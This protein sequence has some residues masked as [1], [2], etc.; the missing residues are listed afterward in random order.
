[1]KVLDLTLPTPQHNLACEEA[2]IQ[3]CEEDGYED[4]ILRFWEPREHFAVLGY[5]GKVNSELNLISC[6]DL[7]VPVLRRCSG[8]GTVLQGPGCLNYALI[9]R[10]P[11][12]EALKGIT[13]T[14][15]FIMQ[16]LKNAL[17]PI[18]GPGIE[19][20]G[21]SDLA[22]GALKFSGN[23]QYRKRRFL[24]F[25]GTF[26]L[27]FD[28][29][30]VEKLLPIPLRQPPYRQ[31]RS[32]GDFLTNLNLPSDTIKQTLKR[33]WNATAELK[34]IPLDRIERLVRE[35]YG[36]EEWTFHF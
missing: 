3:W 5:S 9:L 22:L 1:M 13:E 35:R 34:E 10:I 23:A 14:N 2:L 27:R 8:G 28:I 24:L 31:N 7:C 20:Q 17:E 12:R 11:D 16:R 6:Q 33:A 4:E 30:L 18:L 26:L 21:F 36:K 32:H 25:H 29:S 19:I 15:A